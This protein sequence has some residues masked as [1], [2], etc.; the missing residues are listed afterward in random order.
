M[1]TDLKIT[2]SQRQTRLHSSG[3]GPT[4]LHFALE[5]AGVCQVV[6]WSSFRQSCV[7][8][9]GVC[10]CLSMCE[11]VSVSMSGVCVRAR[12]HARSPL[13]Q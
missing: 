6:G 11:R 9:S 12:A 13:Y 5:R 8:M 4:V 2:T 10:V 1:K 3:E 7:S